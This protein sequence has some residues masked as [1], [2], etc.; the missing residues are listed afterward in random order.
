MSG[1]ERRDFCTECRK[2]TG[3]ILTKKQSKRTVRGKEY[4]FGI[5]AAVCEECGGEMNIP[6]LIDKNVHEID[7]QYRSAEGLVSVEDIGKLMKIYKIGKAPLSLALGFGEIT[8]TR[9]LEG[10]VPSKEYSD[11]IKAAL[12]SPEYMK[13]KLIENRDKLTE[14]AYRK[15]LAAA[16]NMEKLFSLSD[17]MLGVISYL[18]KKLEEVPPLTLQ[19][20]LYF[21]QG[22]HS[23]L[24]KRP[25]F[26]E[27]CSAWIRGPVYPEVYDLFKDFKYDPIDDDRFAVLEGTEDILTEDEKR[28]IDLVADTFGMYGGKVLERITHNEDPWMESGKGYS[29]DISSHELL[30]KQRIMR[31]YIEVNRKYRID[32]EEGLQKY[33]H[34]M[35][36]KVS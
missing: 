34:D 10:Q 17:K 28:V 20:L 35:I 19:K 24:Y 30:Q 33:I 27:D 5:T 29:D 11:V 13:H 25:L 21:I 12:S 22:I 16:V 15:S 26:E 3:Y 8:I 6:G 32:T 4:I 36:N 7:E 14:A 31:Y 9:Y 18:F 23:A 2:E 1:K